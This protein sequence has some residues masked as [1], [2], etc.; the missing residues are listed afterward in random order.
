[1]SPLFIKLVCI[2]HEVLRVL[3]FGFSHIG[4]IST[5]SYWVYVTCLVSS[6]VL[7]LGI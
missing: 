2:I 3:R 4:C 1:M 5:V 6:G 7:P